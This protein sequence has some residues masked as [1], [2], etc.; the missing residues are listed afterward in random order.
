M[1]VFINVF[2]HFLHFLDSISGTASAAKVSWYRSFY[3][4][5]NFIE[6]EVLKCMKPFKLIILSPGSSS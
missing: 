5:R 3:M 4:R 6:V 2:T 1:I